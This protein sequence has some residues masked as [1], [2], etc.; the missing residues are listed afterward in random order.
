MPLTHVSGR[1][2]CTGSNTVKSQFNVS[3]FNVM[4]RFKVQNIVTK[5][6]C[7]VKKSQF[8]VKSQFKESKGADQGH[9]LNR[10]F[11]VCEK[12]ANIHK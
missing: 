1:F 8:K 2:L 12:Y 3:R 5:L 9:S 11:S 7:Y 4:S 6:K 10:D